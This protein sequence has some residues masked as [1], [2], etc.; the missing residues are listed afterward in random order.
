VLIRS[1][2]DVLFEGILTDLFEEQL[3][4]VLSHTTVTIVTGTEGTEIPLEVAGV[5]VGVDDEHP[6]VVHI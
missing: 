5:P 3:G 1:G 6:I 4:H 2:K